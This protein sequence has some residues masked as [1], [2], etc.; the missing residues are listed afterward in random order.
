MQVERERETQ[1]GRRCHSSSLSVSVSVSSSSSSS[2]SSIQS[3]TSPPMLVL[4]IRVTLALWPAG[5]SV[6]SH[7]AF[8]LPS[9]LPSAPLVSPTR[10]LRVLRWGLGRAGPWFVPTTRLTSRRA[11]R[12]DSRTRSTTARP[13]RGVA[14]LGT[15]SRRYSTITTSRHVRL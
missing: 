1:S 6:V 3:R 2:S 10:L 11:S 12:G 4:H 7:Q 5:W 9:G 8:V 15:Y 14:R 13:R